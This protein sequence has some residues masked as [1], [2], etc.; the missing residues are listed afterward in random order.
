MTL[1]S[2]WHYLWTVR[3]LLQTALLSWMLVRYV[4]RDFP[5]FVLYNGDVVV[6]TVILKAMIYSAAPGS[7]YTAVYG[8]GGVLRAALSFVVLFEI[9]KWAFREYPAL[10]SLGTALFR[11]T[12]VFFLL[13]GIALVGLRPAAELHLLMPKLDLVDQTVSLMQCGLVIVLLLFSNGLGL[14]LRSR[15]FGIALGFGILASVGLATSAIRSRMDPLHAGRMTDLLT[16]ITMTASL[17]SVSVWTA[18]LIRT[19][20]VEGPV[21][22]VLPSHDL[23]SWNQELQ[24]LVR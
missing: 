2:L 22:P 7:R 5:F 15:T 20:T 24:R 23:E 10:R 19:D 3:F 11:G 14:S 8:I 1:S 17:C 4:Y 18:Y 9:F 12:I 6:Q 21:P 16:L 13:I